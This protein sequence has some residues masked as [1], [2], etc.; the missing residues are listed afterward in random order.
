MEKRRVLHEEFEKL[1][2]QVGELASKAVED[3]ALESKLHD[4]DGYLPDLYLRVGS[5][6]NL[7]IGQKVAKLKTFRDRL[8][9]ALGESSSE[10]KRDAL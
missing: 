1:H 3:D 6:P 9:E 4:R 8:I 10:T 7:D 5:D 2:A